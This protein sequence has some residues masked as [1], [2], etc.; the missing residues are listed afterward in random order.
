[1]SYDLISGKIV[2]AFFVNNNA[3]F[4]L[5]YCLIFTYYN[6]P[7]LE[8]ENSI[9]CYKNNRQLIVYY[10][11]ISWLFVKWITFIF[12]CVCFYSDLYGTFIFSINLHSYFVATLTS[13]VHIRGDLN[14][15]PKFFINTYLSIFRPWKYIRY[16]MS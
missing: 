10:Q 11:T 6:V 15:S 16:V 5:R 4:T 3:W 2:T 1:M 7:F 9:C 8:I 14:F 12:V 13:Q